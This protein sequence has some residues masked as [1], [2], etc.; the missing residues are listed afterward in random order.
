MKLSKIQLH[1]IGQLGRFSGKPLE[2]LLENV[3]AFNEKCTEII[4]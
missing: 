3:I 4:S 2:P 1:K